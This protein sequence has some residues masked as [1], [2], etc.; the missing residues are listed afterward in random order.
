MVS[1]SFQHLGHKKRIILEFIAQI[2][3]N[4]FKKFTNK[5]QNLIQLAFCVKINQ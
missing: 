4:N 1:Y 5:D 2:I 3:T